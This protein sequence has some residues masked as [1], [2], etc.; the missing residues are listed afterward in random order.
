[1]HVALAAP[2]DR[3]DVLEDL[4]V[5]VLHE[6]GVEATDF[7]EGVELVDYPRRVAADDHVELLD[8]VDVD[9]FPQLR[10]GLGQRID[11]LEDASE[12]G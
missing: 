1:M 3:G 2:Q 6:H 7:I 4:R 8:V 5:E 12:G 10:L 9:R 11:V